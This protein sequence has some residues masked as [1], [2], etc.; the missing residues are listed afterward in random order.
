MAKKVSSEVEARVLCDFWDGETIV[1]LDSVIELDA[2]RLA[3]YKAAGYIDDH[4][5]AVAYAKSL[6]G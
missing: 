5:E 2:M 1:K 3:N 4:P 6:K